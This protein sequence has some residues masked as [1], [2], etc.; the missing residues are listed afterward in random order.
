MT[1]DKPKM[2]EL[3]K[4]IEKDIYVSSLESTFKQD[5][6]SCA[7]HEAIEILQTEN[8]EDAISRSHFDER[9]RLAGGMADEELTQDFKDGVLTVLEMLKTEPPVTPQKVGRW[10]RHEDWEDD[11]ECGYECSE[12]GMGSD[13]D[14]A[15][16]MRCGAKMKEGE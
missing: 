2:I 15:Y 3:L 12:C 1:M 14:Y 5:A 6:K 7:I 9:V 13:V 11:G 8:C 16:C 10:I 4:E